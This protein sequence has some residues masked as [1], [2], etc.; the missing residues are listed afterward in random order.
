MDI[1]LRAIG[2]VDNERKAIEDDFWGQ[3]ISKVTL[4]PGEMDDDALEGLD[5]FSHVEVIFYMD[6]V[7]PEK[8]V[9]GARHPRNDESLPKF[10]ILAQ[11]GKNRKNQLGLS[12]AE[13]VSVDGYELTLK[14]LDAIDGTPILDIKPCFVEFLPRG[15]IKQPQ[16]AHNLMREYY[17]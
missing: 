13:V 17:K 10:G 8:I 12:F 1:L 16:W 7:K 14:G 6:Q 2:Y 4:D 11:R 9:T 15:D 5:A 3:V